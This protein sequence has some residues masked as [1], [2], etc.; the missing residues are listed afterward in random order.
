M[1]RDTLLAVAEEHADSG[2]ALVLDTVALLEGAL[3][4]EE[5]R[6][7]WASAQ[8]AETPRDRVLTR[9]AAPAQEEL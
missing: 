9:T 4:P 8:E 6:S 3:P 1:V 2:G 5:F 7:K